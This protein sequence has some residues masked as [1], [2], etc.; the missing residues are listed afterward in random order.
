[1][2]RGFR[3]KRYDRGKCE[4]ELLYITIMHSLQW[5][6]YILRALN[7]YPYLLFNRNNNALSAMNS[8]LCLC[9]WQAS[10]LHFLYYS[11]AG[12]YRCIPQLGRG[13]RM[14]LWGSWLYTAVITV[15]CHC[16]LHGWMY[17]SFALSLG[18][19]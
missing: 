1:M 16:E 7:M 3:Q 15:I 19:A 9:L 11:C 4:V 14:P 10:S 18:C 13:A 6:L 12:N 5:S 17:G 2:Q 8:S